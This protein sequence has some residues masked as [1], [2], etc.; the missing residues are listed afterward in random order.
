MHPVANYF[1]ILKINPKFNP[2]FDPGFD[3]KCKA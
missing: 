3:S 1:L 2:D